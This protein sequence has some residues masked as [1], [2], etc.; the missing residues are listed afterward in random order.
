MSLG[1]N[2]IWCVGSSSVVIRTRHHS[3]HSWNCQ[4]TRVF[5]S[6]FLSVSFHRRLASV[7]LELS[8]VLLSVGMDGYTQILLFPHPSF[9]LWLTRVRCWLTR[10]CDHNS[11]WLSGPPGDW[12]QG[13]VPSAVESSQLSLLTTLFRR[14]NF[15]FPSAGQV[16]LPHYVLSLD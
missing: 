7:G 9:D 12:M 10:N 6:T 5:V 2:A 15:F 11:A 1:T 4:G 3:W 14:C 13:L 16:M 8:A